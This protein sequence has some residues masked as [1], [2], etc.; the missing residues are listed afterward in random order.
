MTLDASKLPNTKFKSL[1]QLETR[2]R[3]RAKA[4][5]Q[6]IQQEAKFCLQKKVAFEC[7][8]LFYHILIAKILNTFERK[9]T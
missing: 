4:V 1:T 9:R 6:G 2:G 8:F 5:G 7:N 3:E